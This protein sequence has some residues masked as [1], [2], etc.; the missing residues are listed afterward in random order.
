MIIG[1][2]NGAQNAAALLLPPPQP[3]MYIPRATGTDRALHYG[4]VAA[5]L[6]KDIGNASNQPYI[7]AVASIAELIISTCERVRNNKE[8]CKKMTEKTKE[9]VDVVI[10]VIHNSETELSPDMARSVEQLTDTLHKL[11]S[12]L[13]SQVSGSLLR[14]MLRSMEDAD[15]ITECNEGL[16]HALDVFSV[17]SGI[18]HAK[19]LAAIQKESR[20]QHEKIVT[21]LNE[22]KEKKT[23]SRSRKSKLLAL[24]L[25]LPPAALLPASPKI[26]HGRDEELK[27]VVETIVDPKVPPAI[28]IP[29]TPTNPWATWSPSMT[30]PISPTFS[31]S[32]RPLTP[33]TFAQPPTP[34][35]PSAVATPP[36]TP[37]KAPAAARVTICGPAGIGKTALALAAVH[38][39]RVAAKFDGRRYFVDCEGAG[40]PT[41]L[42]TCIAKALGLPEDKLRKK[43]VI[44]FLRGE[45]GNKEISRRG[46][47]DSARSSSSSGSGEKDKDNAATP[48][49]PTRS[50]TTDSSTS[51]ATA[52]SGGSADSDATLADPVPVVKKE[53][54]PILLVLDA[55]DRVWKP[56]P[57]RNE[58]ED[59]LGLLADIQHLTLVVTLRGNE[60]PRHI[61]WSRP[62]LPPLKPLSLEAA[63]ATFLDIS[64][65]PEDDPDLRE[66]LEKIAM[67]FPHHTKTLATLAS[68][69]GCGALIRRWEA[70]G[71]GML[72]D[73]IAAVPQKANVML[74]G[75]IYDEPESLEEFQLP[76]G[77]SEDDVWGVL[78]PT[79]R[80]A[81]GR[82][83]P[84]LIPAPLSNASSSS[85][86]GTSTPALSRSSSTSNSS[87]DSAFSSSAST[88]AK[89]HTSRRS[90]GNSIFSSMFTPSRSSSKASEHGRYA[91][92]DAILFS[93]PS[94]PT[95]H[96]G[97]PGRRQSEATPAALARLRSPSLF[98]PSPAPASMQQLAGLVP[99]STPIEGGAPDSS[100]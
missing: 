16:K 14:R 94:V 9:L 70:E 41:A 8:A 55:L 29:L 100:T 76:D 78:D 91:S 37:T 67:G 61:K 57:N 65:V 75:V 15:L 5:T 95:T 39:P 87:L 83:F 34:T 88:A 26:F 38:H 72:L 73:R 40:D 25:E 51:S 97:S 64:D 30:T 27:H 77:L 21:I 44:N 28:S 2:L 56:H 42:I 80:L 74:G 18:I 3:R 81:I 19:T 84:A 22:K 11:H 35:T 99:P 92:L 82:A 13:R 59:F 53:Q 63:Q 52:A 49:A 54:E 7:Q 10:N 62:F 68:F 12:F 47:T 45:D 71:E 6:M 96:P 79:T 50:N 69:E 48:V 85:S 1:R 86:S 43:H 23:S 46:S 60:R 90:S 93:L 24:H 98:P 36:A 31:S 4:G 33:S 58:V 20:D 66:V 17:Q 32:Y 89:T